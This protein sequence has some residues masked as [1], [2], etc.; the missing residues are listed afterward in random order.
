MSELERVPSILTLRGTFLGW[1][2]DSY[3]DA[4]GARHSKP[5]LIF[6]KESIRYT[7]SVRVPNDM[8]DS[9][10]DMLGDA[11]DHVVAVECFV[12]DYKSLVLISVLEI[13]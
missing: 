12:G 11:E 5:V 9:V 13:V 10:K 3:K 4:E 7:Q 2:K 1:D 6:A 8:V